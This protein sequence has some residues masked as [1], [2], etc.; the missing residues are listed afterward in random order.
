MSH[1]AGFTYGFFGSGPVDKMY[2]AENPLGAPSLHDFITKLA[3]LPL[4]YDPGEEW[5]YSV[6]VDVQ[7]YLVE[8]LSGQTL[9]D[10]VRTRIFEPLGMVGHRVR[11][12]GEQ[13]VAPGDDL[14]VRREDATT[15]SASTGSERHEDA[16]DAVG[17]RRPLLDRG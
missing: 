10:F 4:A 1:M 11:G 8:K 5:Q 13:A 16:G 7:G 9:P 3:K 2:L 12:P 15:R 17:R 6:S 14:R